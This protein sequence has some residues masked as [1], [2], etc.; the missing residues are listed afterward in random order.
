MSEGITED[1]AETIVEGIR[2]LV[3][4]VAIIAT[5][6]AYCLGVVVAHY[7]R[8]WRR[9]IKDGEEQPPTCRRRL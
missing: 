9:W 4:F 1:Q 3:A 8:C 2:M 6:A 5:Y 7:A